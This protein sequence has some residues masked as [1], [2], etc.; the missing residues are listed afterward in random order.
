MLKTAKHRILHN[1]RTSHYYVLFPFQAQQT[2]N[3]A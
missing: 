1:A 2:R 3:E